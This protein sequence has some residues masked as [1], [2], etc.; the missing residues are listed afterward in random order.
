MTF[1][2]FCLIKQKYLEAKQFLFKPLANVEELEA[3]F[4]R[5]LATRSKNQRF[6]GVI[7][8]G[9][10]ESSTHSTSLPNETLINLE[11]DENLPR[12]ANDEV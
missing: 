9:V 5:V 10:E 6:G 3:L 11:E 1:F 8:F 2:F 12:N 4:G 7:A